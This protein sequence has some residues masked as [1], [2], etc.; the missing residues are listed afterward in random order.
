[1]KTRSLALL[2][3]LAAG[4]AQAQSTASQ[5]SALSLQ[6]SADATA[7][8]VL[9]AYEGS[10]F[11]VTALRPMGELVEVS[12]EVTGRGA[13]AIIRLA[14][15]T[16]AATGLAV[17]ASVTVTAVASGWLL[18]AGSEAIAFVPNAMAQAHLHHREL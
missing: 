8:G 5:V 4:A 17:G 10:Q 14:T 7:L 13:S 11:I 18:Q 1:M 16:V 12:L 3:T 15:G 6:A 9:A 2:L